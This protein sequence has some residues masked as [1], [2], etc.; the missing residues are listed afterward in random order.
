MQRKPF[1]PLT[2]PQSKKK[3]ELVHSDVCGPLQAESIGGS[4]Y[5]V[6]FIDDYSRCV[7]VYFIKHK[8]EVF[9]KFKLFEAMVTKECGESIIKLRTD[10]G[11]EYVSKDFQAY[12]ASKGIEHQ[13]TV[14]HSPQQNGVAEWLNRT[15]MQSARSMLS[16]S[17][18]PNKFWAEAVA[19]AAY[20]RN[21]TTTSANE[22]QLT[23]FEKRY[24]HKSNISHLKVFGCAA[25]SLVPST[26]RRKLDKKAR[27]M[28]FIGYSKNPKGYRLIDLSTKLSPEE[29]LCLMKLTFNFS[30]E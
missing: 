22:E 25:Y 14:P 5:F 10:N 15:L 29:M 2:H 18:M 1:K 17:N 4:R 23:P 9:E 8:T 7:S 26:E 3:L 19:T 11:G 12:L 6:T 24:G 16:H 30:N 20:L 21:R 28:C 13:L 27:R